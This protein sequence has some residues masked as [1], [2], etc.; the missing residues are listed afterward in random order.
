MNKQMLNQYVETYKKII[1]SLLPSIL[2]PT[3]ADWKVN[4][5]TEMAH[6][7][8]S[9]K[10]PLYDKFGLNDI[11]RRTPGN[12]LHDSQIGE[13][14]SAKRAPAIRDLKSEG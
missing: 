14:Y 7:K 10:N 6:P 11:K 8:I 4:P 2:T 1:G 3:F 13:I 9:R 12:S 5:S